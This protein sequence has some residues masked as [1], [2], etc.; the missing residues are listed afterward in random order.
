MKGKGTI[1]FVYPGE[2]SM[3]TRVVAD[4]CLLVI[5][6]PV[7]E[8]YFGRTEDFINNFCDDMICSPGFG[9]K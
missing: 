5:R 3:G 1:K 2:K 6:F 7:T 8:R 9:R 4:S